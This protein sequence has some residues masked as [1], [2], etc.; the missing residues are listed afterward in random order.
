MYFWKTQQ[1][2]N[3]KMP[4]FLQG[5]YRSKV[6]LIWKKSRSNKKEF[7]SYRIKTIHPMLK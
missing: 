3:L 5:K 6:R 2:N 4:E 7:I 1:V